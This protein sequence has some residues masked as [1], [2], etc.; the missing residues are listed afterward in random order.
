MEKLITK[1]DLNDYIENFKK[2]FA[3]EKSIILEGDINIHFKIIEELSKY[4]FNA[5][6]SVE[7]LDSE[8]IHLQKQGVL[9]IYE[10]YEFVKIINYFLYLKRFNFEGK[11]LEWMEKIVIPNEILN[12]CNFFDDKSKLKNGINEDLDNIKEAINRNKEEIKQ[13]LY[14][15]VNSP[16]LRT[17]LV[18]MQVHFINS[19]ECLLVRGGFNHA[20]NASVIDRSNSGFF[21]VVPHSISELKQKRSDLEN[22]QEEILFKICKEISHIFEKNLLFLKFINKEFDKFDHYQARIFFSKIDDKNFILPTKDGINKLVEFSHPAL[23][24]AKPI[25]VDF[26]KKV[27]MLTGVNAGGKTMMLK[28]ILSAIF[29][30]KY[31]LPYKTHKSTVVS[32][33]K[34]INAILDDPQSVKNDISTFA[35]RMLEFS[36]LFEVKN[37]IIGVDEIELGTDSDEAAS[38]FKVIIEDLIKNDIKIIITTH[39]KRLAALMAA[40]PDVELIAALYDEENQRPTYEFLQGTIGKSYAFET[41]LRYKI[42]LGVVKRAK[43]VYGEDKDRLNELIERSSELER[44]YRQKIANLDNEIENYKRLTSNLKEQK[45]SLDEHIYSEKSKLH[46]EYKDARDEAKKAIKAKLIKE[47]HQHLNISHKM[48]KD[49]EIEKVQEQIEFKVG[50]RVK[51]RTTKGTIVSIK[52]AKAF[53]ENDMGIKVQVMISDLSR[54]GNPPPKIPTKKAIVNIAK[55]ESGNIKL[56]LH[57]QRAEE[58]IDNLDK[59]LSDALLAGFEEVLVYHGIGTGK[60][61]FAVKEFLKKHPRVKGFED[62]HPSSG[63]FGAKV[64]K[65]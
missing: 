8:L 11:L 56:D 42:P 1:L 41:A 55:P 19:E 59:F 7:N 47:S 9:K 60:L 65:L 23:V 44:E 62:A 5:P 38:L 32:N 4:N 3:R 36:K 53:I 51:Y 63:G 58:A 33:F 39:H 45:E 37:A 29:L 31:L 24:N 34:S 10:I 43:E 6:K 27:I 28:S 13:S 54:S 22:K 25:S 61:A 49:I 21:Y 2:L 26:S 20:L 40:N 35:G 50:D 48:A 30:S 64:I 18:D 52:G 16:K 57:G 12:I 15:L 17:Y 14:K 46:K